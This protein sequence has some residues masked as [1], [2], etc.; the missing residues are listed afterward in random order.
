MCLHFLMTVL[1]LPSGGQKTKE[2]A[3]NI[4]G[5]KYL[6]MRSSNLQDFLEATLFENLQQL[7]LIVVES[8]KLT[9]TQ[10]EA[11]GKEKAVSQIVM[12]MLNYP[13]LI[14]K[15]QKSFVLEGLA[16]I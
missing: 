12:T 11:I 14:A 5:Q 7:M 8:E 3:Q 2:M 1:T 13:I 15:L 4:Y 16:I 6:S 10:Q 9:K